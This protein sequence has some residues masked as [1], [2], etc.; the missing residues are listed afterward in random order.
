MV[1]TASI[2]ENSETQSKKSL[3]LNIIKE[4]KYGINI[5][6]IAKEL[7]MHRL[8]VK[9]YIKD[10][11]DENKIIIEKIGRSKI[12]FSKSRDRNLDGYEVL[13]VEFLGYF[14]TSFNETLENTSEDPKSVMKNIGKKMSKKI[15][16]PEFKISKNLNLK[17]DKRAALDQMADIGLNF[18]Q[19]INLIGKTR[20]INNA[21][22]GKKVDF[23]DDDKEV[24]IGL[25]L[26]FFPFEFL[27]SGLFYYLGAGFFE[28]ILQENFKEKIEFDV[29]M[30]PP[31][32]YVCYYKISIK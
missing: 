13:V 7:K 20:G 32:K 27:N 18:L 2:D 30:I 11:K 23:I 14:L 31:E 9:K 5:S 28:A 10:L 21:I 24:A 26:K 17:T 1:N 29:H 15:K 16:I 22:D 6:Q 4:K 8:T 25:R 3:I 12:C 19:I